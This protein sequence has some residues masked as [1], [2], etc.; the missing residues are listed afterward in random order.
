MKVTQIEPAPFLAPRKYTLVFSIILQSVTTDECRCN[1]CNCAIPPVILKH[2]NFYI[3]CRTK[4]IQPLYVYIELDFLMGPK[5]FWCK[6]LH[7][8]CGNCCF[9][10]YHQ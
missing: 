1:I 4:C 7:N 5:I 3:L 9:T 6:R 2:H 8:L 10:L